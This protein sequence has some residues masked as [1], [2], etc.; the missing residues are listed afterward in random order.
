VE[1]IRRPL[2]AVRS[3]DLTYSSRVPND[4]EPRGASSR[5]RVLLALVVLAVVLPICGL[6]AAREWDD[7][8]YCSRPPDQQEQG[9]QQAFVLAHIPDAQGF[10]W[11]TSDCDDQGVSV[12]SYRTDLDPDAATETFRADPHCSPP[13]RPDVPPETL[14][15]ESG[16]IR[17]EIGFELDDDRRCVGHLGWLDRGV[18][19]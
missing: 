14:V 19:L 13:T 10:E 7:L 17:V 4:G 5:R 2:R 8:T 16:A 9:R 18:D 15:C 11:E 1:G 12:L 3:T 6:L